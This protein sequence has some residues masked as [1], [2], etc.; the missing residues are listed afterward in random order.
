MFVQL[1]D[2]SKSPPALGA[3]ERLFPRVSPLM[4]EEVR[5]ARVPFPTFCAGEG[6]FSGMGLPLVLVEIGLPRET[7]PTFR[8]RERL[9]SSVHLL[10]FQK[11]SLPRE[12]LP[13]LQ[14][15]EGLLPCVDSLMLNELRLPRVTF[16]AH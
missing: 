10:M 9:P 15:G 6:A 8:T 13:A 4:V 7:L 5:A 11:D 12:T 14:T 2:R 16:A 3:R 1:S